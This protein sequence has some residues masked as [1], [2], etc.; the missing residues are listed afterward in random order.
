MIIIII[1]AK[2]VSDRTT[3]PINIAIRLNANILS[4]S[5]KDGLATLTTSFFDGSKKCLY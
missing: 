4:V 2:I 5:C 3:K 1:P